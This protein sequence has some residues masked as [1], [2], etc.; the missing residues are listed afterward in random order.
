MKHVERSELLALG[1]YEQIRD[2]FRQRVIELKKRRRIAIGPH[3]S[4][5]FENHDTMLLQ[6]QEMLRTERISDERA[7]AHELETYNELIAPAG[8]VGG[9][10]FIEYDDAV[11]RR[12]MLG[13]FASLR[14]HLHLHVGQMQSTARFATHFGEE[15]HRLPAVNYATFQLGAQSGTELLDGKVPAALEVSHP[16]YLVRVTL[17]LELRVELAHDL[18][19]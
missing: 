11:E 12:E 7:I 13:K 17:P 14:T 8:A 15:M 1:A 16:D 6:I 4:L 10:L 18:E 19:S 9:T 5:V 3:M 2:R